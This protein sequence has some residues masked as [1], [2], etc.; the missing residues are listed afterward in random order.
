M[1]PQTVDFIEQKKTN[2][3]TP[4]PGAYKEID[5]DPKTGRFAVAK[6]GDS[7]FSK[8]NPNT[9]R[10]MTIKESPGPLSYQEGDSL[11]PSAKYV[12]S[13]RRGNGTRAFDHEARSTF[14]DRQQS[15][16][17]KQP[18]PGYYQQKT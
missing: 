14:T 5:L 2:K 10:F 11:A 18:G 12:L 3:V 1:R 16:Q 7:R 4:G 13:Q 9:P 15:R 6:F 8:I 17:K